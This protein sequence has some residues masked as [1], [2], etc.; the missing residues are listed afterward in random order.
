MWSHRRALDRILDRRSATDLKTFYDRA[1]DELARKLAASVRAGK[2]E[3]MSALQMRQLLAQVR[4]AQSRIAKSVANG[5][6]PIIRDT[7]ADGVRQAARTI[8]ALE[9]K[10]TG[11]TVRLPLEEAATFQG[12]LGKR[13]PSL[14]R[15]NERSF[16]RYGTAVTRKVEEELA[17]SLAI[18]ETP[19]EA[20]DRVRAVADNQWWQAERIVRT[21]G[22]YAFNAAH[23]DSIEEAQG[24]LPDLM[25]RWSEHVDDQ[26][27]AAL[28][29]RVAEDSLVLHGQVVAVGANFVM[30]PDP[31][32]SPKLWNQTYAQPPNR[33]NDR[34][35]LLPW[36]P[37]WGGY[38]WSFTAGQRRNVGTIKR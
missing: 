24:A 12:I 13:A 37:R 6:N 16:A 8:N 36:R 34:S 29:D 21:E 23:A 30:P 19:L 32:V 15:A 1:Q 28:D 22:A 26:T 4:E 2:G 7:Q 10:F 5:F 25:N 33:P 27:G 18:G 3:T 14:I 11:A 17:V 20:I 35:V 38:A 31:R 9:E